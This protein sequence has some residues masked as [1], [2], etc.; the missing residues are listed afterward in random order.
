MEFGEELAGTDW[1]AE[2]F[3]K[4]ADGTILSPKM[5]PT[6]LRVQYGYG[7]KALRDLLST[8]VTR[9]QASASDSRS[10]PILAN[11]S[12]IK[13]GFE[14]VL[15]IDE[16][17]LTCSVLTKTLLDAQPLEHRQAPLS[18]G[19]RTHSDRFNFLHV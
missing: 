16:E 12:K 17:T 14:F 1:S 8:E 18:A 4:L 15:C 6:F 9:E 7:P 3:T 13:T 5:M 2:P 19:Y 10:G 11:Q